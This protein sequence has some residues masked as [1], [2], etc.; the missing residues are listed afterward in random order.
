MLSDFLFC[1]FKK[2]G[3][4][5]LKLTKLKF[6]DVILNCYNRVLSLENGTMSCIQPPFSSLYAICG[7]RTVA[8]DQ[9]VYLHTKPQ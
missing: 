2:C 3:A 8:P 5:Y 6:E 4:S 9:P 1:C 7:R